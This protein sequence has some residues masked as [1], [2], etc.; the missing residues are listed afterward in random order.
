MQIGRPWTH[1]VILG[2]T[3][4]LAVSRRLQG[5]AHEHQVVAQRDGWDAAKDGFV[6]EAKEAVQSSESVCGVVTGRRVK[7]DRLAHLGQ[8][9]PSRSKIAM[10]GRESKD[11]R[12]LRGNATFEQGEDEGSDVGSLVL[13]RQLD[14]SKVGRRHSLDQHELRS[15]R[16]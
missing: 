12:W 8:S 1:G 15:D 14:D 3:H 6:D 11:C 10:Y 5:S 4:P 16:H 13:V 7:F 9:E 2:Q